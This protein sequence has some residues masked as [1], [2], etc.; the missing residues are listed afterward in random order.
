MQTLRYKLAPC[1]AYG[2]ELVWEHLSE[3][4]LLTLD[5]AKTAFLKRVLG[6]HPNTRTRLVYL[7]TGEIRFVE[8]LQQRLNLEKTT[9]FVNFMLNRGKEVD[10]VNPRFFSS[11]AMTDNAWKNLDR[12]NRHVVV[13]F[14]THGYH[15][16][17]CRT[18]LFHDPNETCICKYCEEPCD[19]Y[20]AQDCTYTES[21]SHL[22]R[23]NIGRS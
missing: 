2:I 10:S 4:D 22:E 21:L 17:V 19:L 3:R 11:P 5:R 14:A 6:V 13:K 9:A 7:L 1:A 18:E 23:L 20:H 16:V 12:A 8:E 15:H